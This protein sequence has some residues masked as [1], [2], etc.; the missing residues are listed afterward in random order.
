MMAEHKCSC[1]MACYLFIKT[2]FEV[3]SLYQGIF[4][5]QILYEVYKKQLGFI[6][7]IV[8]TMAAV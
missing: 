7:E 8:C 2:S 5:L 4:S 6:L 1:I 3:K